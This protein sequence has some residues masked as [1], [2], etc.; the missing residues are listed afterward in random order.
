MG[1]NWEWTLILEKK[2]HVKTKEFVKE[3]KN[4]YKKAKMALVKS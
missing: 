3:I 1:E 2:K 4:R